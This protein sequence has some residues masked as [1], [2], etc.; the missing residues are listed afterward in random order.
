V[1]TISHYGGSDKM[2]VQIG[3]PAPELQGQALISGEIKDFKL[4]EY[5]GKSWV[6][7]FFYPLDFTFVC[8]TEIRGFNSHYPEF[9]KLGIKIVGASVDSVYSH[10]A[11]AKSDLGPLKFPLFADLTKDASRAYGVLKEDAGIALRGTFII[12]DKGLVRSILVNDLGIG[13]SVE[14]TLR[15]T[16][17]L[18]TGENTP[19]EWHPGQ[20]TL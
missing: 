8:P 17:A 15:T 7:L 14:E 12:D 11:W 16:Q 20:K 2:S 4:S 18:Q 5:R 10:K 9:E 19:C 13:R 1:Q 6:V 3:Q